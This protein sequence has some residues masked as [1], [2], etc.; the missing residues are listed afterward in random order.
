[1]TSIIFFAKN[2]KHLRKISGYSQEILATKLGVKRTTISNYESGLSSPDFQTVIKIVK[3]FDISIDELLTK[4]LTKTAEGANRNKSS[5]NMSNNEKS[6][7]YEPAPV[8]SLQKEC[9]LCKQ[10]DKTIEILQE[11][12]HQANIMLDNYAKYQQQLMETIELLK[13]TDSHT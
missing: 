2:I 1:M 5:D 6:V 8:Y 7:I 11:S 4:D 3:I 13:K 12:L 10:K 9:Q